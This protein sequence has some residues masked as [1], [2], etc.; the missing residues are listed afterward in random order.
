MMGRHNFRRVDAQYAVERGLMAREDKICRLGGE[1]PHAQICIEV[2]GGETPKNKSL[3]EAYLLWKLTDESFRQHGEKRVHLPASLRPTVAYAM[4][5]ESGPSPGEVFV[6]PMCGA[7]TIL[8]E[9][10][11]SGRY[12]YLL[13]GDLERQ[14]VHAAAANIGSRHK[15]CK[16][17]RWDALRLP[18]KDRSIDKIACNLPFGKQVSLSDSHF[19]GDFLQEASRVLHREGRMVLLVSDMKQLESAA[20]KT[21]W[22]VKNVT[23]IALLG[24]RSFI[25]QLGKQERREFFDLIRQ[26]Q[27]DAS[28]SP[29][30]ADRLGREAVSAVRAEAK[31]GRRSPS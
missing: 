29:D 14:A 16:L 10:A 12:K 27:Q 19:Y 7:G 17:F 23:P 18:L 4:V 11:R 22:K 8:I 9:R 15:P 21:N 6:D 13:G 25:V 30:A 1:H 31:K 5:R 28:L 3:G 24:Q 26:V 20:R 2:R